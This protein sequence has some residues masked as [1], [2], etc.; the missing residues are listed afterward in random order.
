MSQQFGASERV[1]SNGEVYLFNYLVICL[2]ID[3][4]IYLFI[5]S[6]IYIIVVFYFIFFILEV[7]FLPIVSVRMEFFIRG[8]LFAT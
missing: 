7:E 5:N 2:F 1:K 6:F 4:L 3:L 8:C